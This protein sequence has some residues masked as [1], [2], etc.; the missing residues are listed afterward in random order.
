MTP[1]NGSGIFSLRVLLDSKPKRVD[2]LQA[3]EPFVG[4][5]LPLYFMRVEG[6]FGVF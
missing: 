5:S 2:G 3:V 4:G 1:D 6:V